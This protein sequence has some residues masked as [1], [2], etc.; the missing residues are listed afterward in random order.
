MAKKQKEVPVHRYTSVEFLDQYSLGATYEFDEVFGQDTF[1][2]SLDIRKSIPLHPDLRNLFNCLK[3]HV[4]RTYNMLGIDSMK[5]EKNFGTEL[6]QLVEKLEKDITIK[7]IHFGPD[8]CNSIK[9]EMKVWESQYKV[10]LTTPR[11]VY[12][13]GEYAYSEELKDLV[14]AIVFES[15]EYFFKN[16]SSQLDLFA[17]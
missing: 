4:I 10:Q 7:S 5:A 13:T 1:V 6:K 2:T 9:A 8:R 14:E 12:E 11:C 3:L 16:K 15:E 17:V